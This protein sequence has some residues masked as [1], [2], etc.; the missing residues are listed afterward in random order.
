[1]GTASAQTPGTAPNTPRPSATDGGFLATIWWE[2]QGG[3]KEGKRAPEFPAELKSGTVGNWHPVGT[4]TGH[5]HIL[6]RD[7]TAGH[8]EVPLGNMVPAWPSQ[9][10]VVASETCPQGGAGE[11][12]R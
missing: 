8:L 9:H 12:P 5:K 1:M 7:C 10:L 11:A 3:E 4:G 2:P 6:R